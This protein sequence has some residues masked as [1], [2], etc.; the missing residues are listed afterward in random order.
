M[1]SQ[2]KCVIFQVTI[3]I[4]NTLISVLCGQPQDAL[5]H[6]LYDKYK[7]QGNQVS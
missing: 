2:D 4:L 7:S 3:E 6:Y 1:S 5:L